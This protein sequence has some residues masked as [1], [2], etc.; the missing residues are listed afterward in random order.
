MS[1]LVLRL[2]YIR[3]MMSQ[4]LK[5]S[6]LFPLTAFILVTFMPSAHAYID[7]GTGSIILQAILGGGGVVYFVRLYWS[8]LK[9]LVTRR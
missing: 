4:A 6:T 3:L 8:R 1:G 5:I 2:I 7:P 9:N